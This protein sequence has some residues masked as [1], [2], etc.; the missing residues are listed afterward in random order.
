MI[1][2]VLVILR[3]HAKFVPFVVLRHGFE[4]SFSAPWSTPI[5]RCTAFST[6]SFA[7]EWYFGLCSNFC[8]PRQHRLDLIPL[9]AFAHDLTMPNAS[10]SSISVSKMSGSVPFHFHACANTMLVSVFTITNT[11][12]SWAAALSTVWSFLNPWLT[13]G[14]GTNC[15]KATATR[16]AWRSQLSSVLGSSRTW[17][18][19]LHLPHHLVGLRPRP[20]SRLG[21]RCRPLTSCSSGT[22]TSVNGL[23][24]VRSLPSLAK[25]SKKR[26]AFDVYI[27]HADSVLH[28][29]GYITYRSLPSSSN[30]TS[31]LLS[32]ILF[33]EA[34]SI[35]PP[36][37]WF[38]DQ[39]ATR[40]TLFSGT[41]LLLNQW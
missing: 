11:G 16:H 41:L 18:L 17:L 10:M 34:R 7:A 36:R 29:Y 27:N 35:V 26:A 15:D 4:Q 25:Q 30:T 6:M 19:C 8:K 28:T 24:Q 14:G 22:S 39:L 1:S 33:T 3:P 40:W 38:F 2:F 21:L 13:H 32:Q 31:G 5:T 12:D 37:S 23:L 20:H 9:V